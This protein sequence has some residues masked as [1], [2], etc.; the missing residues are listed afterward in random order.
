MKMLTEEIRARIPGL[1]SQDGK[2]DEAVVHVKFFTPWGRWTWYATE[3]TAF[4]ADGT[5]LRLSAVSLDALLDPSSD[6][7]DVH[8]FGL[9]D[10]P[11]PELGYF[12]LR[13][14]QEIRGPAGLR[15]ERD[16]HFGPRKLADVRRTR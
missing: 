14:M 8:F 15:I 7:E 3:A 4:M 9:V 6:V 10:G 13:E 5:E 16:I 11:E 1:Y 12:S 2:G